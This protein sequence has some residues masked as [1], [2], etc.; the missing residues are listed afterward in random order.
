MDIATLVD[1]F[2]RHIKELKRPDYKESRVRQDYIDPFWSLLGW[3]IGNRNQVAP[4]DVEVLIEPSMD[5]AEDDG[6]RS[7]EPDYLFRILGF[8]RFVV[9]AQKPFVD[10]DTDAKAIFQAKRYAWSAT[11]VGLV[12]DN[13][14]AGTGTKPLRCRVI[15]TSVRDRAQHVKLIARWDDGVH[16]L[17]ANE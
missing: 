1:G 9:E 14:P 2:A 17:R 11:Q 3:D 7:R 16:V 5:S 15:E 8:P 10:L 13:L 12:L 6:L 4:Q